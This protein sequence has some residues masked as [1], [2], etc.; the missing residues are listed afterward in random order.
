MALIAIF[1]SISIVGCALLQPQV[2]PGNVLFQDDFEMNMSG[3]D[4][5]RDS[6]YEANYDQGTYRI[7]VD[8]PDTMVWSL[9]NLAYIDVI[10]RVQAWRSSGPENNLFGLLCRYEDA[11]NFIFFALSNDGFMGIGQYVNGERSLLTD[12]SLLPFDGIRPGD[13]INLIEARC[14]GEHLTLLI[15]GQKAAETS[16]DVVTP[17]DV[18]LLVG[19]YSKGGVEIRF[20]NFSMLQP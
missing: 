17:G 8:A 12:E 3:W 19:T 18:G 4:R 14:V 13:N 5:Y 16:V 1:L 10:L 20:D 6:V 9:P 15:N 2:Q 7:K 11:D